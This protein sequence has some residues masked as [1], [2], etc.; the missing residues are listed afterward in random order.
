[1]KKWNKINDEEINRNLEESRKALRNLY[2]KPT[3]MMK[4]TRTSI[5]EYWQRNES[6]IG[7]TT[8]VIEVTGDDVIIYQGVEPRLVKVW[9]LKEDKEKEVSRD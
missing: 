5:M 8:A 2:F 7:K 1:M 4:R 6:G 3:S 9:S